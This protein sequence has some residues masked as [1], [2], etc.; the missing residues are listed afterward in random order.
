MSMAFSAH[1]RVVVT[2]LAGWAMIRRYQTHIVLLFSGLIL[3]AAAAFLAGVDILPKG[4]KPSGFAGFDIF[5]LLV[6]IGKKQ[7]S[8][9]GFLIMAAGGFAAYM[10]RI[11]AANALVRITVS[12]LRKL[13]SP[14][15]VLVLGYLI[16]QL[17]VMVIPSAAGL[18]M[19]LLVALYPILKGVGVSP[20]AAVAVIGVGRHD[21]RALLRHCEPRGESR[22]TRPDHLLRAVSATCRDPDA[23]RGR[24]LPLLYGPA[25]HDRKGDDVYQDADQVQAKEVPSV[26]VW[27]A[28]FPLLPIALM[29][30][31]SKL[32]ISTVKLDTIAA[33]FLVW[34]LVI[35]VELIR[36][37]SPKKIFK[38]AMAM[39]QSMGKM[40]GGI[41]ALIICAEFFANGLK[42]S[43]VITA[44]INSAQGIGAGM[45]EMAV[46]LALI[47]GLVTFLTGSG[48]GAYSS[49]AALAPDVAHGLGG[50]V[51]SLVTPMQFASG[52]FRAMSPV[53]GVIIA[54]AGAAGVT[55]IAVVRR[56]WLPMTVGM[57]VTFAANAIFI[58]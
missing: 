46:I 28:V 50:T 34:V 48:V 35:L 51:A 19:L 56:T 7:A 6:S 57:I 22:G 31:F 55:P 43:G 21:A 11:G 49:F 2:I 5:N 8:G 58:G 29:I 27:Y 37:R 36:L 30:I 52:M 53:A 38:D 44:L 47:V 33:L 41:V 32:V 40:F 13:N 24:C 12:P 17:L 15:I 16:G 26:P 18:A 1:A 3:V 23:H 14:Y 25:L 39:F 45:L 54:V 10:E 4:V 20:A 9:I 42:V